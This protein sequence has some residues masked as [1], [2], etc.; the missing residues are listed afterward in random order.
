MLTGPSPY[1]DRVLAPGGDSTEDAAV[2]TW[3]AE[4][5]VLARTTACAVDHG[6]T[7]E[8]PYQ[9]RQPSTTKGA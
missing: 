9:G 1:D 8:T 4:R 7:Y 6:S 5:D 2:V 3:T